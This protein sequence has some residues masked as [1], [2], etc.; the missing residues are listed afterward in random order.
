MQQ[1]ERLPTREEFG[2]NVL[3]QRE[4]AFQMEQEALASGNTRGAKDYSKI[5]RQYDKLIYEYGL[6]RYADLT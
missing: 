5:V 6:D 1:L 4:T 2:Q 3:K